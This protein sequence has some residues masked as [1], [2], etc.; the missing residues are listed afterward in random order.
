MRLLFILSIL[1]LC[2]LLLFGL[3]IY[4]DNNTANDVELSKDQI[5]QRAVFNEFLG[6]NS[7]R[8]QNEEWIKDQYQISKSHRIFGMDSY[9][10]TGEEFVTEYRGKFFK[11]D[12][13]IPHDEYPNDL[14]GFNPAKGAG[15]F[16]FD[17][18]LNQLKEND[19]QAIPVLARNLLYTN[20]P[21]DSLINV[22]QIPYDQGGDPENPMDYK[23]YSSFLFQFTA[24]YGNNKLIE[25][26]GS[27]K[28]DLLKLTTDNEIKA[29]LN[30]VFAIEPGNEMDKDWFSEKE[31][32]SPK[33]LAAFLSAAIDGHMGLMGEGHGI[34]TADSTMRIL[35]P[36]PTD[37][38]TDYVKNV[39]R[40]LK[41]LRSKAPSNEFEVIPKENLIFT[42]H[43]YPFEGGQTGEESTIVEETSIF[44]DS[45][46]FIKEVRE[47]YDFP[48]Y[49]TET[50]YDKVSDQISPIGAPTIRQDH[51]GDHEISES[52]HLRHLLRLLFTTYAAGYDKTFLFT[53]KD[54]VE[55]GK[56]GYQTKF[57]TT[58]LVKKQGAKYQAWY[59]VK[60]LKEVLSGYNLKYVYMKQPLN[61][62]SLED[63]NSRA[64][65]F[66]L[67]TNRNDKL[68][69]KF[70]KSLLYKSELY[71]LSDFNST[72]SLHSIC[73]SGRDTNTV[74][75]T[76]FPQVLVV[77]K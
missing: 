30:L 29:G 54:P 51:I 11:V 7:V 24:R 55:V 65:I 77:P 52:A 1:L 76:E 4:N 35:F 19:I 13:S 17:L 46:E 36:S 16:H 27:I 43:A 60:H 41:G 3:V 70:P 75:F 68:S 15:K 32:A 74:K 28:K 67:G 48:V 47:L 63:D 38:K 33:I 50:G 14:V 18:F 64:I 25:N 34:L 42:A 5:L 20:V 71:D 66:W 31:Y 37:I 44:A 69:L 53:L 26:G 45:Y 39:L 10:F 58:G 73:L 23:A 49:L 61:L 12:L 2:T 57:A 56:N 62:I 9:L 72:K 22:W 8:E 40:H 59:T 21:K 6:I